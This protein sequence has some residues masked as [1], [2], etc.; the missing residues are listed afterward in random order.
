M[1][2]ARR[3]NCK[4]HKEPWNTRQEEGNMGFKQSAS[5]VMGWEGFG[6]EG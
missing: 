1:K 5:I 6:S 2:N 4:N 3:I